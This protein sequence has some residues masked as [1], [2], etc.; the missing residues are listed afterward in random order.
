M[1]RF[2]KPL[3]RRTCRL[4]AAAA[5]LCAL[6]GCFDAEMRRQRRERREPAVPLFDNSAVARVEEHARYPCQAFPGYAV[7]VSNY[8]ARASAA[9]A[10]TRGSSGGATSFTRLRDLFSNETHTVVD[11][12]DPLEDENQL[13]AVREM[14]GDAW[15]PPPLPPASDSSTPAKMTSLLASSTWPPG[16][17]KYAAMTIE[18]TSAVLSLASEPVGALRRLADRATHQSLIRCDPFASPAIN[19]AG[20][21]SYLGAPYLRTMLSA[22]LLLPLPLPRLR[23]AVLGVGGGSLPSFLQRYFSRDMMRLDLVDAEPQCFRAAVE[24]LGL[25]ETMRGGVMSCHVSDAAA[26]LKDAVVGPSGAAAPVFLSGASP[27]PASE[28]AARVEGRQHARRYDLLF[29]DIFVGS[30]PPAFL[31]SPSFLQLCHEV[32]SSVGVAAFNLPAPDPEFT[33]TCRRVFGRGNVFQIPVPASANVV[34]LARRAV[35]G[36]MGSGLPIS[37]RYFYRR[38]KALQ[39]SHALPYDIAGHY[40]F[41]WSF[42]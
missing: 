3:N 42:W 38:A 7:V 19:C 21:A 25:R 22:F 13:H 23:V 34:V 36:D 27:L 14:V 39:K 40:P 9:D 33:D 16:T 12:G 4:L 29:V 6:S 10:P 5:G 1:S 24:D 30:E 41:W 26:F 28:V 15:G 35:G 20:D 11:R 37:H 17:A 18:P 31:F 32:L 8:Y 2:F